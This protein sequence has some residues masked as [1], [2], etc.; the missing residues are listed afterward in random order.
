MKFEDTEFSRQK[1]LS[2]AQLARRWP[3]SRRTLEN[4]RQQRKGPAWTSFG[5]RVAYSIDDVIAYENAHFF[6][7]WH[8]AT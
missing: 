4:W 6:G 5:S 7:A 3:I 1:Y 8:N 2:T